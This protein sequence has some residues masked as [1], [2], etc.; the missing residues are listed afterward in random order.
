[1]NDRVPS[2]SRFLGQDYLS[3]TM[4]MS[5]TPSSSES[6]VEL[7]RQEVIAD[8][9]KLHEA[10]NQDLLRSFRLGGVAMHLELNSS[11]W[12]LGDWLHDILRR[13]YEDDSSELFACVAQNDPRGQP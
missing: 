4:D 5:I 9:L 6:K 10:L 3:T 8:S 1:M 13:L 11:D 7:Q 2:V 12:R